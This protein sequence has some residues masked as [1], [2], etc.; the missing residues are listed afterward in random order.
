MIQ[1]FLSIISYD[2]WF[3]ISHVILH[4]NSFVKYHHIHHLD[5]KPNWIT[6]YKSHWSEGFFQ[7]TGMFFPYVVSTY[8]LHDTLIILAFL[9]IRGMMRHDPRWSWLIG[10]HHILHHKYQGYNFGE[11][12]IDTLCGTR[13]PKRREYQYGLIYT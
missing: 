12:W 3:Y 4:S 8:S 7:G 5:E 11:Y 6:T 13:Y 10:N 1:L 2:I 9:N